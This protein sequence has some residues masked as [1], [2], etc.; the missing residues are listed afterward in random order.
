MALKSAQETMSHTSFGK[1]LSPPS[2]WPCWPKQAKRFG[3]GGKT[4]KLERIRGGE[5]DYRRKRRN[6]KISEIGRCHI[7]SIIDVRGQHKWSPYDSNEELI[8]PDDTNIVNRYR[9][10]LTGY[11]AFAIHY[12]KPALPYA[13]KVRFCQFVVFALANTNL[14]GGPKWRQI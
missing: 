12:L 2:V 14:W 4:K 11:R 3:K 8:Q 10:H 5:Q 9:I 6:S 7:I 1:S 13:Q